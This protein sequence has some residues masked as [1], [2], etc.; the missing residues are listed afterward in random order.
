MSVSETATGSVLLRRMRPGAWFASTKRCKDAGR[1]HSGFYGVDRGRGSAP[2]DRGPGAGWHP[3]EEHLQ[4]VVGASA[5]QE[6]LQHGFGDRGRNSAS[7]AV[8]LLLEH[9]GHR[10]LRVVGRR[11][12]DEPGG[13]DVIDA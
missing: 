9:H 11:E 3:P 6:S 13:V 5:M 8:Y 12:A 1:S 4:R 7:E 10:H 2:R